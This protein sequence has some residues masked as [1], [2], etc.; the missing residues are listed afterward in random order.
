MTACR[1]CLKPAAGGVAYHKKCL[2][3][4]FDTGKLPH[5]DIDTGKLH[6]AALAMVGHTSLSGIQKKVSLGLDAKKTLLTVV[7]EGG[8]YILKPQTGTYP[9]IPENELVTTRM[10]ELVGI[11]TA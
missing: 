5:L 7:A 3:R 6:T 10:A 2:Q 8:T 4:L 9:A 1:I 11:E